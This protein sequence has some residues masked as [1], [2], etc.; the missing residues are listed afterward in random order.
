M[1]PTNDP[2]G[3]ASLEQL[4]ADN[5]AVEA[6]MESLDRIVAEDGSGRA[7][8]AQIDAVVSPERFPLP[9]D[10]ALHDPGADPMSNPSGGI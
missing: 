1:E 5:A 7:Q 9:G 6:A 8:A 4:E 2:S 3:T 10:R